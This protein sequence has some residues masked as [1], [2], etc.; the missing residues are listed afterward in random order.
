[1][2]ET[3]NCAVIGVGYWGKKVAQEYLQLSKNN[4][5]VR[6]SMVCDMDPH[7]LQYCNETLGLPKDSLFNNYR[8]VLDSDDVDAIHICTPNDTHNVICRQALNLGKHVLL[9]KPMAVSAK[10]AWELVGIAEHRQ[11]ILQV[12]HIFRF[13]NALKMMKDLIEQNYL[14]DLYYVKL[15]WTT[16]MRSPFDR[17]IIYDLG[18][19]PIDIMNFLLNEWPVRVT[20]KAEAYR[21]DHLEEVAYFTLEFDKKLLGHVELSWLEPGKKRKITVIG[22]ERSATVDCLS[23]A[24][25]VCENTDGDSF[26]LPLICN[27]TLLDELAHFAESIWTSKNGQNSGSIGARNVA[28]LESLKRSLRQKRTVNV[29]M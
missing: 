17:D 3:L 26:P 7:N 28:V 13:N 6:L 2:K 9:E 14:G 19:H 18:P 27:N 10:Q 20:C 16:L 24:V 8:E 12:G 21:R 29:N 4:P 25:S 5:N 23:Q 22:S 1:V 15:E 11:L